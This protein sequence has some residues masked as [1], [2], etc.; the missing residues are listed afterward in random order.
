MFMRVFEA[1]RYGAR[2][3]GRL[4]VRIAVWALLFA[5]S[6]VM[7]NS[8]EQPELV[9]AEET[10]AYGIPAAD[11]C[12]VELMGDVNASGSVNSAD[13]IYLVNFVFVRGPSPQPCLGAGDVNCSTAVT[14]A[15]VIFLVNYIFKSGSEPCDICATG[16]SLG[17]VQ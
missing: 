1:K 3:G 15:D 2:A 13:I 9:K 7:I 11:S 12:I 10:V 4:A 8:A 6:L 16:H 5:G 17:C 14:S